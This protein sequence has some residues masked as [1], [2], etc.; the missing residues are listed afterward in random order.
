MTAATLQE[1]ATPMPRIGDTA[2]NFTATTTQGPLE[3]HKWKGDHW[4]ILFSHPADF[5]PVCTTELSEFARRAKEFEQ[6]KTKLIGLSIDSVHAH[7]AWRENI[8]Q[9]LDVTIGYPMIAD[10][11]MRVAKLYGML[12]PGESATVTVR[13][14]FIIDPKHTIRAL[15]YYPLNTGRNIDE[16]V[17]LLDALQTADTKGVA[18]PVNWKP[19]EKVI[20]PPPKTEAEVQERLSSNFEKIDFYLMKKSV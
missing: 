2:P 5:T 7:L 15:V 9:K 20:V 12:H 10:S 11:D 8:K 16:V 19:G 1:T 13:A 18:C 4:A 3:L 6:R 17:R 14:V